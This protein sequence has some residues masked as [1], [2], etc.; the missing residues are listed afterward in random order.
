[1][2]FYLFVH[3]GVE[4]ENVGLNKQYL[5]QWFLHPL[6]GGAIIFFLFRAETGKA[7]L[8]SLTFDIYALIMVGLI[9]RNIEATTIFLQLF[10]APWLAFLLFVGAGWLSLR[11]KGEIL[12]FHSSIILLINEINKIKEKILLIFFSSSL[13]VF[14]QEVI[15]IEVDGEEHWVAF[16]AFSILWQATLIPLYL[17]I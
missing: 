7:L 16:N 8:L 1:M 11:K 2:F 10:F 6:S 12:N 4:P 15:K 9:F 17:E 5:C 3:L 13:F 14:L